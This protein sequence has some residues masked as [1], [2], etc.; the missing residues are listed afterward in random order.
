MD[1]TPV[2][3]IQL[4]H[5]NGVLNLYDAIS[6]TNAPCLASCSTKNYYEGLA[7][8]LV[9]EED[10]SYHPSDIMKIV[11][12]QSQDQ[13]KKSLKQQRP[14]M[15]ATFPEDLGISAVSSFMNRQQQDVE[16]EEVEGHDEEQINDS[17]PPSLTT[18][19]AQEQPSN[20]YRINLICHK[21]ATPTDLTTLHLFKAFAD[22][23]KKK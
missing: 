17:P 11:I 10:Y 19:V 9:D 20:W 4:D 2:K 23:A 1:S 13:R 3:T 12:D 6:S 14:L 21:F 16:M 15:T 8:T 7:D 5:P 18:I 22:A